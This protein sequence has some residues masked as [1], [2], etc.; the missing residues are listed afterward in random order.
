V[1]TF[2]TNTQEGF[3]TFYSHLWDGEDFL[4]GVISALTGV[5]RPE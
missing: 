5:S 1:H 4:R 3:R 2:F